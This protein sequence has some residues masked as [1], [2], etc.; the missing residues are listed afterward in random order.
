MFGVF[1]Q[2]QALVER[3]TRKTLKCIHINNS[4][5]YCGPFD[6]CCWP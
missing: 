5:E 3:E 2:F 6:E 4:G 1:K